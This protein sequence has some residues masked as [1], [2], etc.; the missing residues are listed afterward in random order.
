MPILIFQGASASAPRPITTGV[1]TAVRRAV[2]PIAKGFLALCRIL[3]TRVLGAAGARPA[4]QP[5]PL[6]GARAPVFAR[7]GARGGRGG[8]GRW[9]LAGLGRGAAAGPARRARRVAGRLAV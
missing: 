7:A 4:R 9:R 1:A 5:P 8:R 6:R 2:S 3:Q